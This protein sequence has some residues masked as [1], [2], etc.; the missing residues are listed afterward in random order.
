[1]NYLIDHIDSNKIQN[2]SLKS[3]KISNI[4]SNEKMSIE[5]I[6]LNEMLVSSEIVF[7]RSRSGPNK[8]KSFESEKPCSH[9][10][11]VYTKDGTSLDV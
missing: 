5:E 9:T 8:L 3:N 1:M 6:F 11:L 10:S 7:F 2:Q 4:S